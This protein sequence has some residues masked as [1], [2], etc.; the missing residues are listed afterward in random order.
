M[1]DPIQDALAKAK[2]KLDQLVSDRT[3]IEKEIIDWKR[4]VDSLTVVSEESPDELPADVNLDERLGLTMKFT[5][6]VR[7]ALQFTNGSLTAPQI[8]DQLV[9]I[10]FDFSKYKQELVPLHNTLK[11]LE[12]QGEVESV[13]N[14]QGQITGYKWIDEIEQALRAASRRR[15][16]PTVPPPPRGDEIEDTL[17]QATKR[18]TLGQM[19]GKKKAL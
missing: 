9:K 17:R 15:Y 10:G 7:K 12:E 8:R 5:D 14:A 1:A 6:G 13:R 18:H 11:R 4:V 19:I 3:K 16:P 2:T